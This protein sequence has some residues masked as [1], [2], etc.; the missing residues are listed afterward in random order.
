MSNLVIKDLHMDTVLDRKVMA[1]L[2][3][4]FWFN[5]NY[6]PKPGDPGPTYPLPNPKPSPFPPKPFPFPGSFF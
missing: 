5:Q 6:T 3:G 4:G 1:Q 2:R